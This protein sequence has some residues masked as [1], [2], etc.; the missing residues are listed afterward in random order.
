MEE[1]KMKSQYISGRVAEKTN[2]K[3]NMYHSVQDYVHSPREK[4]L[5]IY[6]S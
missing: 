5:Y 4:I 2:C 3:T 6:G 1:N